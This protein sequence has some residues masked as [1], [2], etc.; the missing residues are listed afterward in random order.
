MALPGLALSG[1]NHN[2]G[3]IWLFLALLYPA[4]VLTAFVHEFGHAGMAWLVGDEVYEIVIGAGAPLWRWRAKAFDLELRSNPFAGGHIVHYCAKGVPRKWREALVLLGGVSA[5]AIFGGGLFALLA[6]LQQNSPGYPPA[7]PTPGLTITSMV[8]FALAA[9]QCFA[10]LNLI[11]RTIRG[12]QFRYTDG[13]QLLM[14]F[15]KGVFAEDRVR[16]GVIMKGMALLRSD[17]F[18]AAR[19]HYGAAWAQRPQEGLLFGSLVHATGRTQ[20]P[21]AAVALYLDRAAALPS[22]ETFD[23]SWAY[24]MGNVAWHALMA[25]EP[26]WLALADALSARAAELMPEPPI[27]ATRGAALVA[28]GDFGRGAKMIKASLPRIVDR[29]DRAEFCDFLGRHEDMSGDAQ[30]AVDFIR[31]EQHLLGAASVRTA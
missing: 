25:R 30:L 27:V 5:N 23:Q 8:L 17:D 11:P 7:E 4:G 18:E 24:A 6:R 15:G 26:A 31:L 16:A 21:R 13:K 1:Q 20:G 10:M 19:R 3:T 29:M 14:L 22:A 9:S 28:L 12:G 2:F